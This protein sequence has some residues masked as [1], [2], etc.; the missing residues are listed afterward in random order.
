MMLPL[1]GAITVYGL[2]ASVAGKLL[3]SLDQNYANELLRL[4]ANGP[5]LISPLTVKGL[6]GFPSFHTAQAVIVAW[7]ARRLGILFYP[8]LVLNILVIISTP[9][10]GGHHVVDVMGGFAVAAFA[11]WLTSGVTNRL[12]RAEPKNQAMP[13]L[14]TTG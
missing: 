2:P 14:V 8:F 11:I 4:W 9:I 5:G 6:V 10:Q 3:I 1:F 13:A 12:M 7:Y